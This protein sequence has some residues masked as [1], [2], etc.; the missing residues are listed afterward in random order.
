M[1]CPGWFTGLGLCGFGEGEAAAPSGAFLAACAGAFAVL[2]G[3]DVGVAGVGV[4]PAQVC[5]ELVGQHG[6][7][8][9]VRPAYDEGA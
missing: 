8:G 6:V 9:V 2:G 5:L 3:D 7:V 4:A 1:G